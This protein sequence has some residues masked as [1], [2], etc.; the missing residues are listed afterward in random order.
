VSCTAIST[1]APSA[2]TCAGPRSRG[3]NATAAASATVPAPITAF[4][5]PSE[6]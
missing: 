4:S 1:A 3:T 6:G 5:H 2:A